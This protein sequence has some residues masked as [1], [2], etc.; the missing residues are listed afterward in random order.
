MSVGVW[1]TIRFE[2]SSELTILESLLYNN[3]TNES[4]HYVAQELIA[5]FKRVKKRSSPAYN[6]HGHQEITYCGLRRH[7]HSL[8]RYN[9]SQ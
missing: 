8:S 1:V 4:K 5:T 2:G 9:Y 6:H 3:A 7:E